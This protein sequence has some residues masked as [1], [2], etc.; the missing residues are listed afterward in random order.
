MELDT[1]VDLSGRGWNGKA[2][3]VEICG[4]SEF[5]VMGTTPADSPYARSGFPAMIVLCF[6]MDAHITSRVQG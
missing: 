4:H 3:E 5:G 2:G 1:R 6:P